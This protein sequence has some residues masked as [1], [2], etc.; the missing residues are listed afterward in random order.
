MSKSINAARILVVDNDP[1]LLTAIKRILAAT[2]EVTVLE[3]ARAAAALIDGGRRFDLILSDV[4]MRQ[5]NGVELHH[6]LHRTAPDQARRM[7]FMSGGF[8]GERPPGFR[9][10]A[11]PFT[12][13]ELLRA[14]EESLHDW[15]GM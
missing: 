3:S 9:V 6:E 8:R 15:S 14:V 11:K 5:L 12:A 10:L 2:H 1:A 13:K 7:I 4:A